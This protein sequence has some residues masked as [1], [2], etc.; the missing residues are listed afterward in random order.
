[1]YCIFFKNNVTKDEFVLPVQADSRDA[2]MM[3]A[4][5]KYPSP[6]YTAL[7]AYSAREL[8]TVLAN[9]ERWPGVASKVQP[10]LDSLMARVRVN[11]S[12]NL[13]PLTKK[14][15]AATVQATTGVV[16]G[17]MSLE[18]KIASLREDF[19]RSRNARIAAVHA[20]KV[21]PADVSAPVAAKKVSAKPQSSALAAPP[22]PAFNPNQG[23]SVV[24]V[25]RALRG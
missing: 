10:T 3:L 13:P 16:D 11:V 4:V 6:V 12:S 21:V 7:T 1:M 19:E 9:A 23:R 14:P 22:A 17:A 15:T 2:A 24:D 8:N 25:L 20:A 5:D 18:A